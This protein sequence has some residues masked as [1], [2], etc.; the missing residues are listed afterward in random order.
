[1]GSAMHLVAHVL[2]FDRMSFGDIFTVVWHRGGDHVG[3][4]LFVIERRDGRSTDASV[5]DLDVRG[6]SPVVLGRA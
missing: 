2:R 6:G 3:E 4:M 1:M 5:F